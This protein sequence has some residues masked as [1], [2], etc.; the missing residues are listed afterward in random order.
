MRK[1]ISLN[2]GWQFYKGVDFAGERQQAEQINIPHSWNAIDGQDG[3][4]DYF[5]GTCLYEKSISAGQLKQ[6]ARCYLEIN[7]ANSSAT[8]YFNGEKLASHDGGY[9]TWRVDLTD[10]IKEKNQLAIEVDNAPNDRVYPQMADFTFYGGIYRDVNLILVDDTHFDL[11]YYGGKG[12][13][14]T[15]IVDGKN[16]SVEI[17]T[18]VKNLA[19]G[20]SL[21]YE[22]CDGDKSVA[23]CDACK[24]THT[25]TIVHSKSKYCSWWTSFGQP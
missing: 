14:V 7:G 18:F 16:A 6:G 2:N 22:I 9:S 12:V 17:R 15:P 19:E 10:H 5:R 25:F 13:M 20:D 11:D 3:G 8:V 24:D 4:N 1:I 23:K 21:V